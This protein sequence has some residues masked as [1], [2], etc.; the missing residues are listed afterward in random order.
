MDRPIQKVMLPG[1]TPSGE[2]LLSVLIKRTYDIVAGKK[3]RRAERDVKLHPADVFYGDPANSSVRFESDFVPFKLGTDVVFNGN[4]YAPGGKPATTLTAELQVHK[5]HKRIH[6]IGDRICHYRSGQSPVFSDPA[7]FTTMEIKYERAYGGVDIYSNPLVPF[8]YMR[9]PLGR[10]FAV[11][12][13]AAAVNRLALPN[14]EDEADR[15]TPER[16]CCQ[17]FTTWQQQPMPAGLGWLPR[18]WLPRS[19]LAGILPADRA[20]EQQLRKAYAALVPV[21][22]RAQYAGTALPTMNFKFFNG[23]SAGLA[24]PFL[25]GD[26]GI[27]TVNLSRDPTCIFRLPGDT[28]KIGIDI[29]KGVQEPKVFI[30]TVMI[31]MED[32]QVDLVWRGAIPFEGPD[33][34]P[35]MTKMEIAVQ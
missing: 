29:G 18:G 9:N 28:V 15:L 7:P 32:R 1:Q 17:E 34:F 27:K 31:R 21:Q 24:L 16:L 11:A 5:T 25:A 13:V 30:Q 3:C 10:G 22:E 8:P 23:A 35:K 20:V 14:I 12:N 33:W 4:A 2:H 26:E 6:L 19:A